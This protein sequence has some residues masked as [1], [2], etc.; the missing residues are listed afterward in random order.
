MMPGMDTVK[1]MHRA[2]SWV[3]G[4]LVTAATAIAGDFTWTTN[5]NEVTLAKYA[6]TGGD[7]EI[8]AAVD[9]RPVAAI[10]PDAF[11]D[12]A[13][14]TRVA[15]PDSVVR[16]EAQAFA[17]CTGLA[18]VSI[19]RGVASIGEW[20]F[21]G[22]DRLADLSVD[23]LNPAFG[24]VDGALYDRREATLVLCPARKTGTFAIPSGIV[25][26]GNEAFTHCAGLTEVSLPES[27]VHIGDWAFDSSGLAGIQIP[28]GVTQLGV[29]AFS[30]CANLSQVEGGAGLVQIGRRAFE[31][32]G[33]IVFAMSNGV[34]QLGS[35]AFYGCPHLARV[36]LSEN[37]S[38][39]EERT[40]FDCTALTVLALPAGIAYVGDWAFAECPGL[41]AIYYQ[42][43]APEIG[44]ETFTASPDVVQYYLS[45]KSG[46]G[47]ALG[48]RPAMPGEVPA[49][50]CAPPARA[51]VFQEAPR[52]RSGATMAEEAGF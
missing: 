14:L 6:G 49:E 43:N 47:S 1:R 33:L 35:W 11:S 30:A 28:G 10:G 44:E 23:E 13:G 46:W 20:A 9:G 39:I 29:G 52:I 16:I 7:V 22:C 4:L 42:G 5:G 51:V 19:G 37:L 31:R 15:I 27:L 8:P 26:I 17:Y 38:R 41:K 32:S 21:H 50:T 48:G 40:F 18:Q 3:A 25:A 45:G 34:T 12:C 36:Q 24:S 2:G